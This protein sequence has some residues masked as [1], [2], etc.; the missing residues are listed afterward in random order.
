MN[1]IDNSRRHFIKNTGVLA[2]AGTLPI[3]LV[4]LAFAESSQNF[5]FAYI[6]THTFNKSKALTSSETG[7]EA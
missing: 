7:I 5:S 6:P 4:E 3:S 2:L 1:S